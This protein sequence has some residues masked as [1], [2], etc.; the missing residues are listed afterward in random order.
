[1]PSVVRLVRLALVS[2][3]LGKDEAILRAYDCLASEGIR[4]AGCELIEPVIL[5]SPTT[6]EKAVVT[7]KAAG[8]EIKVL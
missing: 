4:P 6:R 8:F 7:L 3:A 5:V 2:D 1:M